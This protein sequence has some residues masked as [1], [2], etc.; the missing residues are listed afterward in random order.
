[1]EVLFLTPWKN[2]THP[3]HSRQGAEYSG[4]VPKCAIAKGR[5]CMLAS[6]VSYLHDRHDIAS[7]ENKSLNLRPESLFLALSPKPPT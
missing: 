4:E 7:D 5:T 2:Q 1:M 3:K 6:A